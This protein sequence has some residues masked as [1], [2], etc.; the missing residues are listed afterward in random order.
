MI[1]VVGL[2]NMG[3][4]LVR[5]LRSRG[6]EVSVYNRT[7]AKAEELC[8]EVGCR[9]TDSPKDLARTCEAVVVFVSDDAA[10]RAVVTG[11]G[12]VAE[13]E[14]GLVVNASTVTPMTSLQIYEELRRVG[15]TYIEGPVYGSVD[16]ARSCS[17]ISMLAGDEEVLDRATEVAKLYSREVVK[18]GPVPKASVL[19]LAL[20]NVGLAMAAVLAESVALLE[21]WGVD[22]ELFRRVAGM[23]W[24]RDAV[25]RYWSRMFEKREAAFRLAL[26]AK[27]FAYIARSLNEKGLP[28]VVSS[29]MANLLYAAASAGYSDEDY[30]RVGDY[31]RR[32]A[33]SK[34][35]A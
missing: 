24:F 21:A 5:C 10:L 19:K 7:R 28:A 22:P 18:V 11:P 2:G 14:R 8:R 6:L 25:E 35:S 1:G 27:D 29:A 34:R 9:V 31:L 30:P 4:N 26:A 23:L 33:A 32:F 13:A 17:L 15:V 20:N 12:G 3:S 16:A